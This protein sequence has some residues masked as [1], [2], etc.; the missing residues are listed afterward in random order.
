MHPPEIVDSG[1]RAGRVVAVHGSVID[2]RFP[3]GALPAIDE[4]VL[5]DWDG[6]APLISEVNQH[7]IRTRRAVA[8]TRPD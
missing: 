3:A 4:A 1:S 2:V 5:I 8:R 6:G 7:S